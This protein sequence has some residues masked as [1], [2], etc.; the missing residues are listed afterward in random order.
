MQRITWG[1]RLDNSVQSL[2]ISIV[3]LAV[4]NL[5]HVVFFRTSQLCGAA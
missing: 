5:L 1:Q 3:Q 4:I 2:V